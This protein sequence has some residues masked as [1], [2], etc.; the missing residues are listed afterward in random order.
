M[1][2]QYYWIYRSQ[3]RL[4]HSILNLTLLNAA[5]DYSRAIKGWIIRYIETYGIYRVYCESGKTIVTKQP[6]TRAEKFDD[7]D[8]E[9]TISQS[10]IQLEEKRNPIT[11]S[12][13]Q[14]KPN[15]DLTKEDNT[16]REPVISQP[17]EATIRRPRKR[18]D[19]WKETVEERQLSRQA[20]K[21]IRLGANDGQAHYTD[22]TINDIPTVE[23]ALAEPQREK[24]LEAWKMNVSNYA[25]MGCIQ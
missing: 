20:K 15:I 19:F 4:A 23:G 16:I 6:K 25:N 21:P 9:V 17:T 10:N 24:W 11:E 1:H 22:T 5:D 12:N 2:R 14:E 7:S 8:I 13:T 18:I 3:T